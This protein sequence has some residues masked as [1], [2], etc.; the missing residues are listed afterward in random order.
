MRLTAYLTRAARRHRAAMA[1]A[2]A[3]LGLGNGEELVL[4]ELWRAEGITQA[5]LARRLELRAPTVTS[6][7]KTMERRGLV[8]RRSDPADRRAQLVHIGP[9]AARVREPIEAAW[10]ASERELLRGLSRGDRAA[11]ERLLGAIVS[12]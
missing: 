1:A 10:R 4:A 9:A 7:L 5:E 11:L 2:L 6:V 8:E 3:P 12:G